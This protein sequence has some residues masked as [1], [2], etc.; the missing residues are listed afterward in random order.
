MQRYRPI[1][2]FI[3]ITIILHLFAA[4]SY[5][6]VFL[7]APIVKCEMLN[8]FPHDD[9]A[10]T[11]GFLYYEGMFYE[12][13]GKH[14]RSSIR[15][16]ELETGL[17]RNEVRL[18]RKLFGEGIC[19]W[20]DKIYQ[21]TW[22]A[23][24]CFVYDAGSLARREVFKYKGQG[25]GLTTDGQ[26]IFQSNGSSILTLRD[27]YDFA[28][29]KKLQIMDGKTKVYKLNEL[30]YINGLIYCNIWKEDRI[31]VIDPA[32][33]M[34]K[35]WIDISS[36]RPLAGDKAEAANGIAWDAG[37]KRLYVTGKFW[38][39]IFEIKLPAIEQSNSAK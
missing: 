24:K 28:R 4:K 8:H 21:L 31:A 7:T 1:Y 27:P 25:W 29:I 9:R 2:F 34:V 12:S 36:L 26:F 15:K 17:L 32:D 37:G 11:Q 6:R 13:T 22:Q 16:T 10:F 18:A 30:E 38:N 19:A 35:Q 23:G 5:A 39:K 14:G 33:A 20:K 3:T